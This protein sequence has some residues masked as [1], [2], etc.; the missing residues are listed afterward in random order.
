[1]AILR[2][3]DFFSEGCLLEEDKKQFTTA[4]YTTPVDVIQIKR[5]DFNRYVTSL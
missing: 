5:E 4:K 2:S 3:G 1:M